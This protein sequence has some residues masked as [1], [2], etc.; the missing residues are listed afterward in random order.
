MN[1][2][3][4]P[5]D[6]ARA[7][8]LAYYMLKTLNRAVREHGLLRSGD[9]VLVAVSGGKDN[10]TLLD[11]LHRRRRQSA[12][13][14]SLAAGHIESDYHCGRAVPQEWLAA[15]C[16]DRDIPL[17]VARIEV[18]EEL[19]RTGANPCFRCAWHRRRALFEI[20]ERLGCCTVAYGHHADD[21][22]ETALMN[23]IYSAAFRGM[24]VRRTFFDGAFTVIRPLAYVEERDTSSRSRGLA[25]IHSRES[26]C[27]A[28]RT[29]SAAVARALLQQAGRPTEDRGAASSPPWKVEPVNQTTW[30]APGGTRSWLSDRP[31]ARISSD[32]GASSPERCLA[33]ARERADELGIQHIVVASTSGQSG[34]HA[35]EHMRGLHLVVVSHSSGFRG[36]NIEEFQP[37]LRRA[38]EEAGARVLTTQHAFG[39]VGR[40]IR[41][42]LGTYQ[43]D[44]VMAFVLRTFCDGV[45]VACEIT[46]MAADAGLIPASREVIAIGGTGQGLDSALVLRSANSQDFRPPGAGGHLQAPLRRPGRLIGPRAGPAGLPHHDTRPASGAGRVHIGERSG[47]VGRAGHRG[48]APQIVRRLPGI[49]LDGQRYRDGLSGG[50]QHH[51]LQHGAEQ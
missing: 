34:L 11:L 31:S 21:R 7:D 41:R 2:D 24:A 27:P 50:V 8:R 33:L 46:L 47:R 18:A 20:A 6:P 13:H 43:I 22:A 9:R 26:R 36:P 37:E 28:G 5:T 48:L 29:P 15:W 19:A 17:E 12:E 3:T 35:T 1:G 45:K 10:L 40:A 25:A 39:G 44:E 49:L 51:K 16:A 42:K 4:L 32:T 23:L 14:Y 38:I 30:Q